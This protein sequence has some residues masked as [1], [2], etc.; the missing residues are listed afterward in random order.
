[1]IGVENA[2]IFLQLGIV[3]IVAAIAAFLLR[4][5]KQPQILAYV[6]VGILLTPVL[7]IVTD[8][9]IIQ[10]MY[11]IGIAFLLFLVGLEMD[12]KS[13]QSVAVVSS[14]GEIGRASCRER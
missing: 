2:D 11:I 14:I 4:V 12:L 7:H 13:L 8:T 3:V 9:S 5:L 6:V 10:S 1:M